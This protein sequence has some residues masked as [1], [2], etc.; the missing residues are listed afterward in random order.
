MLAAGQSINV[1]NIGEGDFDG[2]RNEVDMAAATDNF[3]KSKAI[4]LD[5]GQHKDWQQREL[6]LNAMHECFEAVP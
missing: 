5:K 2:S 6:A 3:L 4:I 1:V